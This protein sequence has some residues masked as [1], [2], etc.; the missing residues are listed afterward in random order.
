MLGLQNV[1]LS[2][3]KAEI[4]PLDRLAQ[5]HGVS[6]QSAR[7]YNRFFGQTNVRLCSNTHREML[8]DAL[9]GLV[10]HQPDL[11]RMEGFGLY[12]KTQT[13]NTPFEQDWLRDLFDEVGLGHW[14]VLTF[15]MTNCASG[16]A[17]VHLGATMN[18]PF[19]VLT[20][21]KAFHPAGNRLSVGLLGEAG[22]SALFAP[23][24]AYRLRGTHVAHLPRYHINPD[25]M[26]AD[27]RKALQS[28]F[29]AGLIGFLRDLIEGDRAFFDSAPIVIPYN[30]NAPLIA[31]ALQ[32]TGLTGNLATGSDPGLG[33]M[34]CSDN[35]LS[36]VRTRPARDASLFLFAAG[37]GVTFAAI[38]LEPANCN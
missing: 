34:F 3:Q 32:A 28:D 4:V 15:S 8:L 10:D 12:A 31:R 27:D 1:Y 25:D 38:K 29:E 35:Y 16:L 36:L 13:H 18:K 24:G 37:H 7:M 26:A 9:T 21:E 17:A 30:L 14:E 19:V 6:A 23:G 11:L 22:V 20:G 2:Q 5:S 33:H